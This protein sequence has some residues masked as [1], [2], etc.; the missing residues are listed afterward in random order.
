M[1]VMFGFIPPFIVDFSPYFI[2]FPSSS[3]FLLCFFL[4]HFYSILV[5]RRQ[6]FNKLHCVF[7]S[8]QFFPPSTQSLF[9]FP[10]PTAFLHYDLLFFVLFLSY[11]PFLFLHKIL[12]F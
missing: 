7:P 6:G 9:S 8:H 12:S 3:V 2:I 10:V 5:Y 1:R 11:F 4:F